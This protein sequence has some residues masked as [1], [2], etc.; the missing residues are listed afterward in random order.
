MYCFRRVDEK[1]PV[2]GSEKAFKPPMCDLGIIQ[3]LTN[4][5]AKPGF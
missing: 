2:K 1:D 5:P 3:K 4:L